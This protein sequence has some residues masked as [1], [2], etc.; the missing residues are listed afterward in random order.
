VNLMGHIYIHAD[1]V[2]TYAGRS[3]SQEREKA[4]IALLLR[5]YNH[6]APNYEQLEQYDIVSA[7]NISALAV[8]KLPDDLEDPDVSDNTWQWLIELVFGEWTRRLWIVQEQL[9]NSNIVILRG[10][11]LLSWETVAVMPTLFYVKLLPQELANSFWSHNRV[12]TSYD[13]W[14]TATSVYSLWLAR[15]NMKRQRE[16][17]SILAKLRNIWS[18]SASPTITR[19]LVNNMDWYEDLECFDSRDRIYA[20]LAISSEASTEEI[21]PDYTSPVHYIFHQ[22]SMVVLRHSQNLELL[23]YACRWNNSLDLLHPSWAINV[24]RPPQCA[25]INLISLQ[26]NPHPRDS[27]LQ[28]PHFYSDDEG[29]VLVL[30]GRIIDYIS[31]STPPLY[32]RQPFVLGTPHWDALQTISQFLASWSGVLRYAGINL[33]TT[34]ALCR[35]VLATKPDFHLQEPDTFIK[36][37]ALDFRCLYEKYFIWLRELEEELG[38]DTSD[39]ITQYRDFLSKL[40]AAF[41]SSDSPSSFSPRKALDQEEKERAESVNLVCII[42]GRAFCVT[43]RGRMCNGM[44][45]VK[46]G[47]AV[48]ALEGADRLFILRPTG[49]RYR[50]IGDAY[51]DGLMEGEAYEGLNPDEDGNIEIV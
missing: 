28:P 18:R 48:A 19:N 46:E 34:A 50:L 41:T 16:K 32:F 23:V 10:Q 5:L 43:R 21:I 20:L 51:V 1:R 4:G 7:R 25:A 27:F 47:D 22:V 13:P 42:R 31:F 35:T 12:K 37:S 40:Y 14:K 33:E 29:H 26:Y 2:I 49:E 30:K 9:L 6:F 15:R 11:R 38:V 8:R 44:N 17:L 36:E 39:I 3:A 24:P 45:E